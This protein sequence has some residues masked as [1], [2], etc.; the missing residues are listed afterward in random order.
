MSTRESFL[1][2][3]KRQIINVDFRAKDRITVV[4]TLRPM[5]GP[6]FY[7]KAS[8]RERFIMRNE[9]SWIFL[10]GNAFIAGVLILGLPIITLDSE[11]ELWFKISMWVITPLWVDYA[12]RLFGYWRWQRRY[13]KQHPN[14]RKW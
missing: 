12:L 5:D 13:H 4:P 1:A 14:L 6:E 2:I 7:I 8:P 9:L 11:L 3:H 10:P